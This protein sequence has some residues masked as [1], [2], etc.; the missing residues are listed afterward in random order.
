M[1]PGATTITYSDISYTLDTSAIIGCVIP[2]I[3][4][5]LVLAVS[6]I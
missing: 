5:V 4:V 6:T 1:T 3:I 2:E